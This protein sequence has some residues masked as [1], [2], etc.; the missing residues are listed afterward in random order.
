[1]GD[2]SEIGQMD[3]AV[4][5][6][7]Q[8]SGNRHQLRQWVNL[9]EITNLPEL[10]VSYR[11][12]EV[13]GLPPNEYLDKG[14]NQLVKAVMYQTKHPVALLR[15]GSEFH[16][17]VDAS[18]PL[19]E[20]EQQLMPDIVTLVPD[21]KVHALNLS[22]LDKST[23]PIAEEFVEYALRTPLM[24]DRSLWG[25]GRAFF[26][27]QPANSYDRAA[28]VDLYQ[29]FVWNVVVTGDGRVFVAVDMATR[30]VDRYWLSDR[31]NA[32]NQQDYRGRHCLYHYGHEW[33]EIQFMGLTG[34]SIAEEK[35]MVEGQT[36]LT[37]VFQYTKE[38]WKNA[39][40]PYISKLDPDSPAI[41]Y[42]YPGNRKQR[43]GALALCKLIIS[44][45][46]AEARNLHRQ[47][48]LDP[49]PRCYST[50]EV[51]KRHFRGASLGG[52][53]IQVEDSPLEIERRLFA[54]PPQRFGNERVLAVSP[55]P[56]SEAT[57]VV[58][59]E[60]FGRRRLELLL[61]PQVGPL[62]RSSFDPQYMLLPKSLARAINLDFERRFL[63]SMR[64]LSGQKSY[65]AKRILYDDLNATSLYRQVE[66][67]KTAVADNGIS[68]GYTLLVLPQRAHRD[69][70]N[71]IKRALWPHVQFQCATASKL[72]TFYEL[73]DGGKTCV[74]R[75]G[76]GGKLTRFVQNCALGMLIANR[77]WP[78]ALAK[79]LHYEVYIGIDVLNRMAGLT[80]I[81]Q[82]P[83]G[84]EIIFR[85][86]TCKQA[87]SLTA[88]QLRTIVTRDLAADLRRL[89]L[90]PKSLVVHRDGRI[91]AP[92]VEGLQSGLAELTQANLLGAN[93]VFGIV[94]IRKSTADGLRIYEGYQ[95][96]TLHN[97]TV[98]SAYILGAGEGIVC[99]TGWPF[100]FPGTAKPLTA[101]IR[102]GSLDIGWVLE[103]IFDLSQFAFSAPDK[104]ARL[105]LT[106]KL[107][108]DFL[109]PIAGDADEEEALYEAGSI[110]ISTEKTN[111]EATTAGGTRTLAQ[112]T[113]PAAEPHRRASGDWRLGG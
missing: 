112:G 26:G 97:P 13:K 65:E 3:K 25:K 37:N 6:L 10:S 111:D 94:D 18:G 86:Y 48:I 62:D 56:A 89:G 57:E 32:S 52:S 78:W 14:L 24:R 109:E 46:D 41:I 84:Q 20:L 42:Q 77:K 108:D 81:Y 43:R 12:L 67:I 36:E 23:I 9:Y 53:P 54:V 61:D 102:E 17:A 28:N 69:L 33:F 38:R 19:P 76:K 68:R 60:Q 63:E 22:Q 59:L 96:Q 50:M 31:V 100:Q 95:L 82:T 15:K 104:C 64:A 66:A 90:R 34:R 79:P 70:H 106:I 85:N 107:A 55:Y 2:M 72:N 44:T 92:E 93:C 99:T 51:V 1:M 29:G 21:A 75:A 8:H 113:N 73:R 16:L 40:S 47:S 30:Y 110:E 7:I 35:F 45:A 49:G 101:V 58:T 80:F 105:P 91:F 87:E 4:T 5:R 11:L 39:P 103:D 27:R 71:Y 74:P 83:R 98:G 88:K